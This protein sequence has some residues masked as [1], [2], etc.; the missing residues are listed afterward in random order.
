MG[1][2]NIKKKA[3][4]N[5]I[6]SNSRG[7]M[8]LY[9]ED[10]SDVEKTGKEISNFLLKAIDEVGSSNVLQV[11]TDN[12]ANC[13]AAGKE[14]EKLA[15]DKIGEDEEERRVFRHQ[16]A[17]FQGKEGIFGSLAAKIDAVTM[18]PISWWST[19]GAETP[20]LSNVAIKILSQPISSSSAERVWSTYSYI[21][22]IKRNRLNSVRADKLVYIHSNIRLISRF[23]SSYNDG[24]YRKWDIDAETSY[25]DD[26]VARLDEIRWKEDGL[27]EQSVVPAS[28]RQRYED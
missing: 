28:K 13:K 6:A 12:A 8:F 5:V 10:F 19:Y 14:I 23:T 22:N 25:L 9:A 17:R 11:I 26:S 1:W 3:L 21:H 2:T 16:L 7:S 18:S 15:F 27:E 24:P 4:I 20:Q